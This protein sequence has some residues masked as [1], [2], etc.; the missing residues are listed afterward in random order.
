MTTKKSAR[1]HKEDKTLI[2]D[3][4]KNETANTIK[5]LCKRVSNH[6]LRTQRVKYKSYPIILKHNEICGYLPSL[7]ESVIQMK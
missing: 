1:N 6:Q 4:V 7:Y 2:I 5:I 3:A